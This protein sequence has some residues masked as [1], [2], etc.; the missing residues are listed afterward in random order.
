MKL[1]PLTQG[2][3]AMVDDED[4]EYINQFKWCAVKDGNTYYATRHIRLIINNRRQIEMRMHR[5]VMG[6]K[7]KDGKQVDHEDRDGLNCQRYN[8][9]FSTHSQNMANR[10]PKKN[11]TSKY[12]GLSFDKRKKSWEVKI[13]HNKKSIRLGY[14]KNEADGAKAYNEKA[15]ELHGKFASLNVIN[16]TSSK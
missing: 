12:L 11:G 9:R 3:F 8:L 13:Q 16:D 14:F 2:K 5:D 1:I 15:K 7:Y 10:Q 4:F 6:C